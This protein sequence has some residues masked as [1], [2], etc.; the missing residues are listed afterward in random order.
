[1]ATR[2][3]K[4][5]TWRQVVLLFVLCTLTLALFFG[6]GYLFWRHLFDTYVPHDVL[7]L[8]DGEEYAAVSSEE[9][10][11]AV[12]PAPPERVGY[13]FDGWYTDRDCTNEWDMDSD[14][15]T[16]SMTLYAGWI[17]NN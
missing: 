12:F 13:V 14:T 9:L 11:S 5:T 3:R 8:V 16:Q 1:M 10:P 2:T 17:K 7:F 6:G 15:V 4:P